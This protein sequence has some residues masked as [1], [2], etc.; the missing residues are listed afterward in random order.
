MG[1]RRV[2][3][4]AAASSM[5]A[6]GH[7]NVTGEFFL[8]TINPRGES[9]GE[10]CV[11][12]RRSRAHSFPNRRG[13]RRMFG[14]M[15]LR[16]WWVR[17]SGCRGARWRK[18]SIEANCPRD[19][20]VGTATVLA[21]AVGGRY[22]IT[23]PVY[24]IAPAPGEPRG[25]RVRWVVFPCEARYECALGWGIQCA[26]DSPGY[27]GWRGGVYDVGH[28]LGDPAEHNG[29]GPDAGAKNLKGWAFLENGSP[30]QINLGG[31]GVE[32][33]DE[34]SYGRRET[35][36]EKRVPLLT[37]PSQCS[38]PLTATWIRIRGKKLGSS[39]RV[40]SRRWGP[41]RVVGVVVQAG[42]RCCRIR[43]KRVSQRATR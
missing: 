17:R 15:C 31:P 16:V 34:R 6:G 10:G 43:L 27:H 19:T 32:E 38:S 42:C 26:C 14:L 9:N 28:D 24:N 35:V 20:M 11:V 23:V 25:V 1:S 36:L 39:R 13:S 8:N 18:W 12:Y 4:L 29:P 41:R 40:E 33:F 37:G 7:P 30:P 21:C 2:G 22:V 5:Q 3:L